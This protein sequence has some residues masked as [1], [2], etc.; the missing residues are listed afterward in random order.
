VSAVQATTQNLAGTLT[1]YAYCDRKA[2][3]TSVVSQSTS[4]QNNNSNAAQAKCPK[5]RKAVGGGFNVQTDIT[6][7]TFNHAASVSTS[8]RSSSR[9]WQVVGNGHGVMATKMTAYAYCAKRV[10]HL[11][12]RS[13][14]A[15]PVSQGNPGSA[16]TSACPASGARAG[17]FSYSDQSS[18]YIVYESLRSGHA[19]RASARELLASLNNTIQA[20]AYCP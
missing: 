3:K 2:S 20:F 18:N 13:S 5:G 12:T 9:V 1:A 14:H 8:Q 6:G 16:T 10:G 7:S 11:R 17:G 15:E 19:W 4:L